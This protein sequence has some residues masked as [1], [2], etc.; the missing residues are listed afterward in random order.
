MPTPSGKETKA[1]REVRQARERRA[2]A[3]KIGHAR[4]RRQAW[5]QSEEGAAR[6]K[7]ASTH[8]G[9]QAAPAQIYQTRQWGE[10]SKG[11]RWYEQQ[12]P[13]LENPDAVPQHPRWEDLSPDD[14]AK[15]QRALA[16]HAGVDLDFM[17]RSFG[18]QLDQ[19][20]LRAEEHS[21][22]VPHSAAVPY[23]RDF[24]TE[25]VGPDGKPGPRGV[26]EQGA[27]ETDLT[28]GQ[29]AAVSAITSPN[30]KF[31]QG[32]RYP[33]DETAKAAAYQARV[34][35][36]IGAAMPRRRDDPSKQSEGRPANARK[37]MDAVQQFDAGVPVSA[38]V[39]R[40][41]EVRANSETGEPGRQEYIEDPAQRPPLLD[42]K[43]SP[44]VGP[45]HNSWLLDTPDYL[46][47]DVHTAGGGLLPHLSY[48]KPAKLDASG[49]ERLSSTGQ[50]IRDKSEREKV[51]ERVP[52]FHVA[53]DY[54]ARQAIAKRG[55]TS[56]RQAQASQWGEEGILRKQQ[57]PKLSS[58]KTP[59]EAYAHY[60]APKAQEIPGQGH[61]DFDTGQTVSG[62]ER[63]PPKRKPAG[64]SA[65]E[66]ERNQREKF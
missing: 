60:Q 26:M 2:E 6:L 28:L 41:K 53:A 27:R 5:E 23:S 8:F 17:E 34:Q 9:T 33:N 1:E 46:V 11:A 66:I 13:G 21:K 40:I 18:A 48:E 32:D 64:L 14:Q 44:K 10:T 3:A 59:D 25:P 62:M 63:V 29:Y 51:I 22:K 58:M 7:D 38:A 16:L 15:T 24:Y 57:D 43:T 55:L 42:P 47:S 20:Y 54:A 56:I 39:R 36:P 65:E 45:Y 12:I 35:S 19:S 61:I 50:V 4:R 30:A 31:Q 49:K 52:N 37:A